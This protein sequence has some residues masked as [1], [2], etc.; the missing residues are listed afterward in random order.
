MTPL[1]AYGMELIGP[2]GGIVGI[3]GGIAAAVALWT[4]NARCI[5][6]KDDVAKMISNCAQGRQSNCLEQMRKHFVDQRLYEAKQ[7]VVE[8][9][10]ASTSTRLEQ[11]VQLM[12]EVQRDLVRLAQKIADFCNGKSH[13]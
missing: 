9:S 8:T 2:I 1:V 7:D 4:R 3:I 6:S 11:Q 12:G 5:A 13:R 10:I